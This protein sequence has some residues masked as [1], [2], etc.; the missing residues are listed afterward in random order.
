VVEYIDVILLIAVGGTALV[1]LWHY[2]SERHRAK[3]AAAAGEDVV[4]DAEEAQELVL[5]ADVLDRAPDLDG[6]GK[7]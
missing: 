3:E 7:H 5:D 6:D 1:T 2:F 4:T